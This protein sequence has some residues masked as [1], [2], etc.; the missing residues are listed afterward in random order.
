MI[1]T[2]GVRFILNNLTLGLPPLVALVVLVYVLGLPLWACLVLGVVSVPVALTML[3]MYSEFKVRREAEAAGAQLI[4][5]VTG[6]RFG[7]IDI[8]QQMTKIWANGYPGTS[9]VVLYQLRRLKT[10]TGD[11]F[12]DRLLDVGPVFDMRI[13]W[14]NT[15]ITA[16][17]RHIQAVLATDFANFQKGKIHRFL[18][19]SIL[20]RLS[21][22]A[23]SRY[24]ELR[25]GY[26][27]VQCR[28]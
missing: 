1:I 18:R 27:R 8:L 2:P 6:K 19:M 22:A 7:H 24:H 5:R 28:W 11:Y 4:P 10:D 3:T 26:W 12:W 9:F 23:V 15:Y 17:P 21:R 20:R 25:A 13:L 14:D 16:C